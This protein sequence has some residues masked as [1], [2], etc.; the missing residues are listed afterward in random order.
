MISIASTHTAAS[1]DAGREL[2]AT[3]IPLHSQKKNRDGNNKTN[4]TSLFC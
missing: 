1:D 4:V 3:T 2:A